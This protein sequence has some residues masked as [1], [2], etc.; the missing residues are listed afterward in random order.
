MAALSNRAQSRAMF[1]NPQP[2]TRASW[3]MLVPHIE[4]GWLQ[5]AN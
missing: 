5:S 2:R 3:S 4:T 1:D